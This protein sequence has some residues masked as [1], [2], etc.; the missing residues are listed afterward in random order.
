M[1][2]GGAHGGYVIQFGGAES[3]DNPQPLGDSHPRAGNG[4]RSFVC[5]RLIRNERELPEGDFFRM[6]S[7]RA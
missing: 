3:S 2:G 7:C 1:D 4:D 5:N 6:P